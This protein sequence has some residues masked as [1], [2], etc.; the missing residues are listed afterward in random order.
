[1]E[2]DMNTVKELRKATKM[3][4]QNFAAY[5]GIPIAN[6]K[7]W[8][9]EIQNPPAYVIT[10]ITRV[11]KSDGYINDDLSPVQID[12]IQQTRA[13]LALE[14]LALSNAANMNLQKMAKGEIS[15]ED[16]QNDLKRKYLNHE[17]Y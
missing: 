5:L 3:S 9:Q 10:L 11:M 2:L 12:A 13:T 7:N 14:N 15:R 4:Q 8:E 1:M 6:I 17:F 16:F